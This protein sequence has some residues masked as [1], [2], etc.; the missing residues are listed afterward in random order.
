M[1]YWCIWDLSRESL[2]NFKCNWWNDCSTVVL[3]ICSSLYSPNAFVEEYTT[4]MQPLYSIVIYR[5]RIWVLAIQIYIFV[6]RDVKQCFKR[7]AIQLPIP[8]F[9]YH[10]P[11]SGTCKAPQNPSFGLG[12]I[13]NLQLMTLHTN[14]Q[15]LKKLW[16]GLH[17]TERIVKI[18]SIE[19]TRCSLRGYC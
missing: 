15:I 2:Y 6:W 8:R 16:S 19:H 14:N 18:Y 5:L 4:F 17:R 7:V 10:S 11:R 13:H 9:K 1:D 3:K 12:P